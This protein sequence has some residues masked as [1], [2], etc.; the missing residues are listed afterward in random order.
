MRSLKREHE[1]VNTLRPK[2]VISE[3][4]DYLIK[5]IESCKSYEHKLSCYKMVDNSVV[6][7]TELGYT[8]EHLGAWQVSLYE[9]I[10]L[11]TIKPF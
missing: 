10:N 5:V 2:N 3:H 9:L 6:I 7:L 1:A 8:V 11:K 4:S